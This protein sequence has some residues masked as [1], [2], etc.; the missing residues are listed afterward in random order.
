MHNKV[1][2]NTHIHTLNLS[3]DDILLRDCARSRNQK[4]KNAR[5][6]LHRLTSKHLQTHFK[7]KTEF[8]NRRVRR[9]VTRNLSHTC[10]ELV[11]EKCFNYKCTHFT[12]KIDP[13][14]VDGVKERILFPHCLFDSYSSPRFFFKFVFKC[15]LF[16]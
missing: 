14:D 5:F 16:V 4:K 1:S 8:H 10:I 6:C 9:T 11:L 15:I 7:R 2:I 3:F 12:F 13:F